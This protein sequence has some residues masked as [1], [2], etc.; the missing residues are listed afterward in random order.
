MASS[1]RGNA[2]TA[3]AKAAAKNNPAIAK[4][5]LA[6]LRKIVPDMPLNTQAQ[7]LQSADY[8]LHYMGE[9][10]LR[11]AAISEGIRVA[12]ETAGKGPES[13]RS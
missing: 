4:Q 5:A 9:M 6:D 11:K 10:M 2:L 12:D 1:P 7:S 8:H 13:R 3:I